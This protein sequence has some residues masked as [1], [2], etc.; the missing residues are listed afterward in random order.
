M[1]KRHSVKLS[2]GKKEDKVLEDK[3]A[4][5]KKP[6][7]L[8]LYRFKCMS[9]RALTYKLIIVIMIVPSL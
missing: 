6:V 2:P 1:K 7:P 3:G 8:Q 4:I 5:S 9:F